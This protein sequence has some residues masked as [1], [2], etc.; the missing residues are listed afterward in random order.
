MNKPYP[1]PRDVRF[2]AL[3]AAL[4]PVFMVNLFRR[5]LEGSSQRNH[6]RIKQCVPDYIRYKPGV[7]CIVGYNLFISDNNTSLTQRVYGRLFPPDEGRASFEKSLKTHTATPG[8]GPPV[9][10]FNDINMMVSYFPNDRCLRGL[11]FILDPDKLKRIA[12]SC[13]FE[14]V[15][16]PWRIR[17]RKTTLD[18]LS[19]KPERHCVVKCQFGLKNDSTKKKKSIN[20]IAKMLEK[21]AGAYV[22]RTNKQ[23]WRMYQKSESTPII[24]E[25]MAYDAHA[26]IFF[27]EEVQGPY[28]SPSTSSREVWF[29]NLSRT[30]KSLRSFHELKIEGLRAYQISRELEDLRL[31]MQATS[32]VLPDWRRDILEL[33]DR[34]EKESFGLD[35]RPAHTVHG[36]FHSEQVLMEEEGPV[37]IDLDEVRASEPMADVANFNAHL[38]KHVFDGSL[39]REEAQAAEEVFLESYAG[40]RDCSRS[41]PI[42]RWYKRVSFVKLALSCVKY[43]PPDWQDGV[44]FFLDEAEYTDDSRM[45]FGPTHR[46]S[47]H[48]SDNHE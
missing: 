31:S 10:W 16:P 27:Q 47:S 14:H 41:D 39:T 25:P 33:Y 32:L 15:E 6:I 44:R 13:L 5:E 38:S 1:L 34:L 21:G 26:V 20:V 7:S 8:Y 19:Y 9:A 30:A 22:Y 12:Q 3:A 46:P 40:D 29:T 28:P 17:G 24:P 43:L 37:I 18:I 36:D 35:G 2:P 48:T 11:R 4:D 23:I 42:Y 45:K